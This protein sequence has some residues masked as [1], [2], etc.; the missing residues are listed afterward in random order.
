VLMIDND[1]VAAVLTTRHCIAVRDAPSAP[2]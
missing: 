1:V 2:F